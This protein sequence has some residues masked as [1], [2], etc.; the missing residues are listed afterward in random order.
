MSYE[1]RCKICNTLMEWQHPILKDH[2]MESDRNTRG[3]ICYDCA[4][5]HCSQTNCLQCNWHSGKFRECPYFR[6]KHPDIPFLCKNQD[7]VFNNEKGCIIPEDKNLRLFDENNDFHCI[8][9][10]T[11]VN[12]VSK[13]AREEYKI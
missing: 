1:K 13:E 6:I 5:E 9:Y 7:C 10:I 11:D 4:Y 8:N 3:V 12:Q 2:I